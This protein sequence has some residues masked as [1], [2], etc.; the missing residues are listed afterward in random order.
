MKPNMKQKIKR[1]AKIAGT[2][3]LIGGLAFG[4]IEAKK[5][6][7]ERAVARERVA[8]TLLVSSGIRVRNTNEWV[9]IST[10]YKLNP[11]NPRDAAWMNHIENV[12]RSTGVSVPRVLLTLEKN[13]VDRAQMWAI[14]N[15]LRVE[16]RPAEIARLNRV[17]SV[18][19]ATLTGDP[20]L[21]DEYVLRMR[22][23]RGSVYKLEKM[24]Q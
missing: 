18:L 6:S 23:T 1:G 17:N 9:R 19:H 10:I 5:M 8:K 13:M 7:R 14:D 16:K 11:A 22:R 20:K 21:V 4:T 3:A 24:A 15:R 2:A 12:S